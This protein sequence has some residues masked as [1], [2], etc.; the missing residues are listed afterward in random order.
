MCNMAKLSYEWI[1]N[2]S[3]MPQC[4]LT[5]YSVL[6]NLIVDKMQ[7]QFYYVHVSPSAFC[8]LKSK[9]SFIVEMCTSQV[10][11]QKYNEVFV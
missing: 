7:Y 2:Q 5:S 11:C 1:E 9:L 6:S 3:Y 4:M 10:L 8:I